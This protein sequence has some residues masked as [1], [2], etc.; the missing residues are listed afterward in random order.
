MAQGLI[1]TAVNALLI[2]YAPFAAFYLGLSS[3]PV[4]WDLIA[5]SVLFLIALPVA[6]GALSRR[7]IARRKGEE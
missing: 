7:V 4:P 2:L 5:V 6:A 1:N 3:I